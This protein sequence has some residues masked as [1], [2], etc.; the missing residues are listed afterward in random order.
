[1]EFAK[2]IKPLQGA[3]DWPFWKD[4]VMDVLELFNAVDIVEGTRLKPVLS[5][6]P[7]RAEKEQ[8]EAYNK[9]A[10]QAK[11]V[12]SQ[13]VSDD[14]HQ[15][16]SGRLSAKE[17]WD[18]LVAQFDNK[19]E[20]QLFRQCLDFFSMEW[21]E[22]EDAPSVLTRVRNQHREF[23]AG[24]RTRK[25]ETVAELLE[26]L[27]VSK[28]LHIL[29]KRFESF[30]SS[31]LLMK[32]NET[33]K[34][35]DISSALILHERNITPALKSGDVLYAKDKTI[36]KRGS[37][38][39]RNRKKA[40][41]I[42][43]YCSASGHWLQQCHQWKADGKPPYPARAGNSGNRGEPSSHTVEPNN[44]L[45]LISISS[46]VNFVTTNDQWWVDNG[47]TRHITSNLNW[48]TS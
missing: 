31:Y 17:A 27:F 3:K 48:F 8:L 24:L 12:I 37:E 11:I 1:M 47:A 32:A 40:N 28:V 18:I 38:G 19:A 26:L 43:K 21:E 2:G 6:S 34:I 35:E 36:Q 25:V 30:K 9:A 39:D 16:I 46:D 22:T 13:C 7:T 14:L 23:A 45:A 41:S 15:R 42:C 4:R 29:P 5:D 20:D 44:K 10:S 33:K